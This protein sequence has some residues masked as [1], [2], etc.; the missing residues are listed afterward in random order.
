MF[1]E[2]RAT[3]EVLYG[4]VIA[5]VIV[6]LLTPAVGGMARLLGAVDTPG[7]RRLN[8]RP[9]PRLGGLAIFLGILVPALAFLS[10]CVA[11]VLVS[12]VGDLLA[13]DFDH[14]NPLAL[15]SFILQTLDGLIAQV[16]ASVR[17]AGA[18]ELPVIGVD[19]MSFLSELKVI[20]ERVQALA[21]DPAATVQG[22]ADQLNGMILDALGGSSNSLSV[23]TTSVVNPDA[24][25]VAGFEPIMPSYQGQMT[26]EELLKLIAFLK[27]LRQGQTPQRVDSAPPPEKQP[28]LFDLPWRLP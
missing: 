26:E 11:A 6:V 17:G 21:S 15:L 23:Q 10:L 7:A 27:T 5:F 8:R 1:D 2:L 19:L 9:I 20:R 14:D 18:I 25:V 24:D 22:L 3:P 13:F 12:V 4:A 16:E 28:P